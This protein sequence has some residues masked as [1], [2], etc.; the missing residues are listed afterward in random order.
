MSEGQQP[1]PAQD[2]AQAEQQADGAGEAVDAAQQLFKGEYRCAA[3]DEA[4]GGRDQPAAVTAAA[5]AAC[6]RLP[7]APACC[8]WRSLS[9]APLR[10]PPILTQAA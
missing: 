5:S 6:R 10:A 4:G 1:G 2:P 8:L 7:V 9:I 3:I